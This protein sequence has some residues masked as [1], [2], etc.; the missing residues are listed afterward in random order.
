MFSRKKVHYARGASLTGYKGL[1][2]EEHVTCL[3][4]VVFHTDTE[5]NIERLT[6]DWG[7][8]TCKRCLVWEQ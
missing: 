1:V 2:L 7:Q 8:V 4:G 6:Q 3:C 5:A